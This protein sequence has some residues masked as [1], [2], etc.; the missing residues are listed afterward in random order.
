MLFYVKDNAPYIPEAINPQFAITAR[1]TIK[2]AKLDLKLSMRTTSLMTAKKSG[3]R[4]KMID[5]I[6]KALTKYNKLYSEIMNMSGAAVGEVDDT[7]FDDKDEEFL[8]NQIDVLCDFAAIAVVI[9]YR[10]F[11]A[12]SAAIQK[13]FGKSTE[14]LFFFTN[15]TE[16]IKP[17]VTVEE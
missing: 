17:E 13:K 1:A 9:D 14:E 10:L 16:I 3:K 11:P 2:A 15:Q 6:Q 12:M 7:F 5:L 4:D 8:K